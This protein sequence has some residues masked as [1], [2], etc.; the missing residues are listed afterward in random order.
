M[1][2][3]SEITELESAIPK[4]LERIKGGVRNVDMAFRGA[5]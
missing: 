3:N 4:M 1:R 5:C 2:M